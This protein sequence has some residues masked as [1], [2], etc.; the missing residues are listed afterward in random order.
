MLYKQTYIVSHF[1][2]YI[3]MVTSLLRGWFIVYCTLLHTDKAFTMR[4]K[5]IFCSWC[6]TYKK[7]NDAIYCINKLKRI[8][9][10]QTKHKDKNCVYLKHERLYETT[11]LF[12]HYNYCKYQ[13]IPIK[14]M[15]KV[16][17]FPEI[18]KWHIDYIRIQ[19]L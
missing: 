14:Y 19:N 18:A 11:T 13:S 17:C 2:A 15:Y 3:S 5:T 9:I 7:Q 10:R 6:I 16:Q 4:E 12:R 8:I 1:V